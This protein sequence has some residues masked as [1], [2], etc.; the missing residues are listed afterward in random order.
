MDKTHSKKSFKDQLKE[1]LLFLAI[2]IGFSTLMISLSING[3]DT[4]AAFQKVFGLITIG[5]V[6]IAVFAFVAAVVIRLISLLFGKR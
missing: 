3:V 5:A 1:G 6:V 4:G 2:I